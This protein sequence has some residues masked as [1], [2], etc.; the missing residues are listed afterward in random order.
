MA[1]SRRVAATMERASWIRRMFDEGAELR[2]RF[3]DAA[4]VDL[5]LG[6]PDLEPPEAFTRALREVVAE[7]AP[8]KHRYMA[9][10]G[11][12]EARAA[13]AAFVAR[14]HGVDPR[15][16]GVIMTVGAAGALNVVMKSLLDAGSRVI[17]PAPLAGSNDS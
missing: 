8:G 16:D 9:N 7:T 12:P 5:S 13:V 11:L 14:E 1:I 15:P 4:V 3:G 6:N 10:A 2:R 17:C